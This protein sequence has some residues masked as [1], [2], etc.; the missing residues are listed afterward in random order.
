MNGR[1][2]GVLREQGFSA[3]VVKAVLAEQGHNPYAASQTAVALREAMQADDWETLLDAYARCVRITRNLDEVYALR[4]SD[5]SLEAEK[6]LLAAYQ[7]AVHMKGDLADFVLALR[8]M[9]SAITTFFDEVLVMD[10]DT[11]VRENRLAL[12]QHIASL[13]VGLADLSQ[14]QGF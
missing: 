7:L 5:F 13:T 9:E 2:E 14:L 1:F 6:G 10:E 3:S 8:Q 12:L 11:A 4:P